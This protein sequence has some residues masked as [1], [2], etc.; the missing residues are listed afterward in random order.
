MRRYVGNLAERDRP[1]RN[2]DSLA[3]SSDEGR[4]AAI[5]RLVEAGAPPK[6]GLVGLMRGSIDERL[7]R[8]LI[9]LLKTLKNPKVKR[10]DW[11]CVLLGAQNLLASGYDQVRYATCLRETL[12]VATRLGS[13][14]LRPALADL[15]SLFAAE[16][17]Y[18]ASGPTLTD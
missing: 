15:E 6:E 4:E 9:F 8:N 5:V 18:R 3:F 14:D 12:N 13:E 7:S 10:E 1:D 17:D 11:T 2:L 16:P